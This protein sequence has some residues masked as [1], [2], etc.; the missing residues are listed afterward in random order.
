MLAKI[1]SVIEHSP[2]VKTIMLCGQDDIIYRP[3]QYTVLKGSEYDDGKYFSFSSSLTEQHASIT[4]KDT[5]NNKYPSY[6]VGDQL[7]LSETAGNFVVPKD[8]D[9]SVIFIAGGVGVAPVRGI[10]KWLIDTDD[11]RN[12]SLFYSVKNRKDLLFLDVLKGYP[13]KLTIAV[14]GRGD[15]HKQ[16]R[17]NLVSIVRLARIRTSLIYISGS[18]GM[19]QDVGLALINMGIA[20]ESIVTD[21]SIEGEAWV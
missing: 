18:Y 5:L 16:R 19:V 21:I 10:I 12:I 17:I 14:T 7:Y 9:L 4:I 15:D 3:G 13:L 8:K 1:H 6:S 20:K 2:F 11:H